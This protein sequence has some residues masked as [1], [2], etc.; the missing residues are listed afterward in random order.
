MSLLARLF[1]LVAIAVL[2]AIA[3]L[4]WTQFQTY[5][6]RV[7][8]VHDNALQQAKLVASEQDRL[9]DG[10]RQLLIALATMPLIV[11]RDS[12]RCTGY[13][14]DL[15]KKYEAYSTMVAIGANGYSYCGST[16]V[17]QQNIFLGDRRYFKEALATNGFVVG[18]Y[19]EGRLVPNKVLSFAYPIQG[20]DGTRGV[21]L[22]TLKLDWLVD[23]V[24]KRWWN[25][26]LT[27]V[28]ADRDGAILIRLPDHD[29]WVGRPLAAEYRP[30]L[31]APDFGVAEII[32]V[33]GVRRVIGYSPLAQPPVGLYLG[34][35]TS[36]DAAFGQVRRSL[37]LGIGWLTGGTMLALVVA[38]IGGVAFIR[39][40]IA[41]LVRS[42]A[43]WSEGDYGARAQLK[44]RHSEIGQLGALFDRMAAQLDRRERELREATRA[45]TRLIAAAG[46]DFKQPLQTIAMSVERL[47]GEPTVLDRINRMVD[48]IGRSIDQL[49]VAS[50]IELG[51]L[52]PAVRAVAIADILAELRDVCTP[53]TL[54]KELDFRIVDSSAWVHTDP[55][56]MLTILSNL[57][58]NA[59]KYTDRG[60]VLVGCRRHAGMLSVEVYDTG[61]GI[62]ADQLSSIFDEF[63]RIESKGRDGYGLGLSIVRRTADLLIH[64]VRVRSTVGRGSCFTIDLPLASRHGA[65]GSDASELSAAAW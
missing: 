28:M 14:Q 13:L 40:P 64:R 46:H 51:T 12:D 6:T 20:A 53:A 17:S 54:E 62:P 8:E 42:A 33:D 4:A 2:P 48:R 27:I 47:T 15:I 61:V 24:A 21:M 59:I 1:V 44:D 41:A 38:W 11:N 58:G 31:D 52:Q 25:S 7:I 55:D 18:E 34:I 60:R 36:S 9:V 16:P 43:R 56:M 35:G 39:R 22:L 32:G 30:L 65:S 10:A 19:V 26:D 5:Q 63:R 49:L 29:R 37:W 23:Y 3:I 50:R 57:V 45:K